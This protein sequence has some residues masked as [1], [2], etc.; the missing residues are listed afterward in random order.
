MMNAPVPKSVPKPEENDAWMSLCSDPRWKFQPS[1]GAGEEGSEGDESSLFFAEGWEVEEDKPEWSTDN[2]IRIVPSEED[3]MIHR[4]ALAP[5]FVFEAS[6]TNE[7]RDDD[8][9]VYMRRL[10]CVLC[11]RFVIISRPSADGSE[12]LA[13][14]EGMPREGTRYWWRYWDNEGN[15]YQVNMEKF[16]DSAGTLR[17]SYGFRQNYR[18]LKEATYYHGMP[19]GDF[20]PVAGLAW[21]RVSGSVNSTGKECTDLSGFLDHAW[22]FVHHG[23]T[24]IPL[25]DASLKILSRLAGV[26]EEKYCHH[27]ANHVEHV[28]GKCSRCKLV[29]YCKMNVSFCQ[30]EDWPD[31][32]KMCKYFPK[33]L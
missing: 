7:P 20:E 1:I 24:R 12:S 15:V 22:S 11:K 26:P 10:V 30:R 8:M 32:K 14:T 27:C 19:P 17:D 21:M 2:R 9:N 5:R 33:S 29:Y 3:D 13:E 16:R 6:V 28:L 18:D 23:T 4:G 31:H 25:W